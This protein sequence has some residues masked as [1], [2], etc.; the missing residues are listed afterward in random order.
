MLRIL[1]DAGEVEVV[2][3]S[4]LSGRMPIL[5]PRGSDQRIQRHHWCSHSFHPPVTPVQNMRSNWG[6]RI[7]TY[8]QE[9]DLPNSSL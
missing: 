3:G 2:A 6:K 8:R 7:S 9:T 5:F 1:R 4:D